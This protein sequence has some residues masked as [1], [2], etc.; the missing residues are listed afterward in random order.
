[1]NSEDIAKLTNNL[2]SI[3]DKKNKL[4]VDINNVI[5]D[6]IAHKYS[7]TKVPIYRFFI[8]NEVISKNNNYMIEYKC[9]ECNRV[10]TCCLNN[11][12]RKINK[13][14][15]KCRTCK[16]LDIEKRYNH[17][18]KMTYNYSHNN[19]K[20]S[21]NLSKKVLTLYDKLK[22]DEIAFNEM[23]DDWK[24]NYFRRHM[25]NEE[26]EHIKPKIV[27]IQKGKIINLENYIYYP[28]V[29][30]SNQTR[31]NPYLYNV[32]ND[33]N[34]KIIDIDLKCDSCNIIFRSKNLISHKNKLKSLCQE[35]NLCNNTFKIRKY[36]NICKDSILYQSKFELKFIRLCNEYKVKVI[37]GPKIKYVWNNKERFYKVD[38]YIPKLNLLIEIKDNHVWHKDQ[39]DSG[40][41][42]EK[43]NSV[44]K[45]ND[46]HKSEFMIIYPKNYVNLTKK[47]I[48]KY[49][50]NR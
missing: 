17:S 3:Y 44:K 2:C 24:D 15:T 31:F 13:G 49:W 19:G 37:N 28:T 23:D 33:S 9:I 6:T 4:N 35:C 7:N 26:F 1:M 32:N 29:S 41:W 21:K 8:N 46:D 22:Q 25:T 10:N 43:M 5:V 50:N 30:I 39:V 45:Y 16:E 20:S 48:E 14:I 34:E 42:Q 18:I 27:S 11:I 12:T 40:K 38:F 36:Q 47:I